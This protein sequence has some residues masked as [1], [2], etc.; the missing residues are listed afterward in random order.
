MRCLPLVKILLSRHLTTSIFKH[1]KIF[2]VIFLSSALSSCTSKSYLHRIKIYLNASTSHSKG[3]YLSDDF[4]SFFL[5]RK[6]DGKN[7]AAALQSFLNWDGPLH[8]DVTLIN[9]NADGNKWTVEF[10]EQND[11]SKLIGFPGWKGTET[12]IFNGK[13]KI[14]EV[15]YVPDEDNPPYKK[16]LQ[17][18][19]DWLQQ[20]KSHELGEVYQG[21]KLIQSP[22]AARKWVE[23]LRLWHKETGK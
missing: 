8:P 23:L 4:R 20:N 14:R 13:K 12:I 6:G 17:P 10:V 21:G 22:E 9:Y 16:W 18:A 19:V 2:L 1:M 15:L 11:F 7:K 5:E 3:R